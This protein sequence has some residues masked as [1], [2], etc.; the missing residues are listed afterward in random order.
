MPAISNHSS[1]PHHHLEGA[2]IGIVALIA[3]VALPSQAGADECFYEP[4]VGRVCPVGPSGNSPGGTTNGGHANSGPSQRDLD[5]AALRQAKVTAVEHNRQGLEAWNRGDWGVAA[6]QFRIALR[7][8]PE[9]RP[10][11]DNVISATR[12]VGL[13]AEADGD[14]A[15]AI[16][17]F[18][19]ALSYGPSEEFR[20]L[21]ARAR[22]KQ[23]EQIRAGQ[24]ESQAYKDSDQ[25]LAAFAKGNFAAA[26]AYFKTAYQLY[27]AEPTFRKNLIVAQNKQGVEATHNGDYAAALA[28]FKSSLAI[29]PNNADARASAALLQTALDER[30]ALSATRTGVQTL[31]QDLSAMKPASG[32]SYGDLQASVQTNP[33]ANTAEG[34]AA[35]AGPL[36]QAGLVRANGALEQAQIAGTGQASTGR[37]VDGGT[38][39]ND[40]SATGTLVVVPT[41]KGVELFSASDLAR[42]NRSPQFREANSAV[43]KAKAE[44]EDAERLR[45]SLKARQEATIDRQ[46]LEQIQIQ[47][48]VAEKAVQRT[49]G[50]QRIVENKRS[51]VVA[52]IEREGTAEMENG[53]P[54]V[55][56]KPKQ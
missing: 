17:N 3:T 34:R 40:T 50:A 51:E 38:A 11:L 54:A 2:L 22:Q 37:V 12:K 44:A 30:T 24:L 9:S 31:A 19:S 46:A 55:P 25:G 15:Y 47:L 42:Y 41:P 39:H 8:D 23:Q 21:L 32:L 29:D 1:R 33:A 16:Q 13:K 43:T 18:Q 10:I 49:L 45:A 7:Y 20:Q 14:W 4:G 6:E 26:A 35:A 56:T 52:R 53:Q 48:V 27:P 5:R 28:F 36:R